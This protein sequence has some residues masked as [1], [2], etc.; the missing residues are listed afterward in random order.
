M[1]IQSIIIGNIFSFFD[2]LSVDIKQI[3]V[4]SN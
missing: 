1:L 2:F 4:I 3:I